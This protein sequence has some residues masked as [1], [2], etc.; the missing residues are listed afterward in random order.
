MHMKRDWYFVVGAI[1]IGLLMMIT[2]TYSRSALLGALAGIF[3]AVAFSI[4]PIYKRY[5]KQFI[6]ILFIGLLGV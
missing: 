5:K 3:I 2:Y 6:T 1:C 4:R